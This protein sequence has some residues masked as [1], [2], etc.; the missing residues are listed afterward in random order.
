MNNR[1]VHPHNGILFS[2]KRNKVLIHAATQMNLNCIKLSE[3]SQ[4]QKSTYSI[5]PLCDNPEKAKLQ[6]QTT[7]QW[8]IGNGGGGK[9]LTKKENEKIVLKN[10]SV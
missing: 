1:L 2:K 4:I 6:E 9:R 8:L 5:T 3:R 10:C 7:D